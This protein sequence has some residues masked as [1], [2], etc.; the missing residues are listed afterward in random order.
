MPIYNYQAFDTEGTLHK[1]S[2]DAASESEVRQF[3]RSRELFPKEIRTSRLYKTNFGKVNDSGKIKLPK[4]PFRKWTSGKVLTQF[5]RQLEVLLDASI[6]YDKAFQLIIPQTED[7][8][9]QSI[10]S[11]VRAQVVE[12]IPLAVA[13]GKHPEVFPAMYVSMV[14]SGENSGNLG[15]IMKRLSDYYETQER[16]RSKIKGALIYPAFMA[17]FGLAVVIF[18]I[19]NI[20]PKIT[21][22][23]ESQEAALPMPTRILMGISE[24]AVNHWFLLI[25]VIVIVV[26]AAKVFLMSEQGRIWKNRIELNIPGLSSL[27]IKIMVARYCQTLGTLLKSDVDLKTALEISKKVVVNKLFIE[28]LDQMIIDVN[29]K[30]IP[31]S[32]AMAK[33]DYFPE[34]VRHV[35]SIGEEAARLDELLEKISDR[36]QEEVNIL[37]EAMTSLLQPILIMLLGGAVG[38]IALAVLMP[39]LNM[40]QILQ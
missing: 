11:D 16:V 29:N 34:Y 30:G 12:G 13:M 17:F 1:G 20:V 19:T 24:F 35:V 5:T 6:P 10:L 18:M 33:I 36:M 7:S 22:I 21:S 25:F 3:L 32:A 27:R 40:S 26:A 15:I 14:R 8:G 23:F 38:F 39:M 9:F 28:K 4:L 31:L 2:K 37:L